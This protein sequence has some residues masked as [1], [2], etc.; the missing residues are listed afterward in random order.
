M[1][2]VTFPLDFPTLTFSSQ[3]LYTL[4]LYLTQL[5]LRVPISCFHFTVTLHPYMPRNITKR[6]WTFT[7]HRAR[8]WKLVS[9]STFKS[10]ES[11]HFRCL[12]YSDFLKRSICFLPCS[13]TKLIA[14]NYWPYKATKLD[15]SVILL[16]RAALLNTAI[17]LTAQHVHCCSPAAALLDLTP[18]PRHTQMCNE[19]R[20]SQV[21]MSIHALNHLDEKT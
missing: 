21:R 1:S 18:T 14:A 17:A 6:L 7:I 12:T 16:G 13:T 19:G 2:L 20:L 15:P 9:E 11:Q 10:S 3:I 5:S 4:T 8:T